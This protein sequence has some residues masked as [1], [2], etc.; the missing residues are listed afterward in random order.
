MD[1]FITKIRMKESN[2]KENT[3]PAVVIKKNRKEPYVAI[4][5]NHFL[6]LIGE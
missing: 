6:E 1:I 3:N 2:L 5:L 4:P